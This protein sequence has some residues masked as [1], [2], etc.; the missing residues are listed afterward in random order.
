LRVVERLCSCVRVLTPTLTPVL[1]VIICVRR[2]GLQL[3]KIP[4]KWDIVI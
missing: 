3:V 2:Q 4:N 1:I